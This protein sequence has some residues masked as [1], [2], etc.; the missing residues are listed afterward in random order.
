MT[1]QSFLWERGLHHRDQVPAWTSLNVAFLAVEFWTIPIS[2]WYSSLTGCY[3]NTAAYYLEAPQ[4]A[5]GNMSRYVS[6]VK[7]RVL[8]W[9]MH[10]THSAHLTANTAIVMCTHMTDVRQEMR[11]EPK[12]EASGE[13]PYQCTAPHGWRATAPAAGGLGPWH[14]FLQ[15]PQWGSVPRQH[16]CPRTPLCSIC[17]P[18]KKPVGHIECWEEGVQDPLGHYKRGIGMG[19]CVW[20]KPRE[21]D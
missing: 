1:S 8:S 15:E 4:L 16:D 3:L 2:T 20:D 19:F 6:L 7:W 5:H 12:T 10:P 18:A 11:A 17:S 13:C 21:E 14:C 9:K